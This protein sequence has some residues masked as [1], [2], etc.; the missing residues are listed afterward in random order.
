MEPDR[1]AFDQTIETIRAN[2]FAWAQFRDVFP[3]GFL[4]IRE[5]Q[6]QQL[7]D[8]VLDCLPTDDDRSL[9][10][11]L[12]DAQW[13]IFIEQL[14]IAHERT[15]NPELFAGEVHFALARLQMSSNIR[16]ARQLPEKDGRRAM[17]SMT[18]HETLLD[19]ITASTPGG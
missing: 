8:V 5:G 12:L 4:G 17:L 13:C 6:Y 18:R 16:H 11:D 19:R 15:G 7:L 14:W 2:G 3:F 1:F 9:L 10:L